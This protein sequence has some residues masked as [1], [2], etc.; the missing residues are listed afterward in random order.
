MLV[1]FFFFIIII[2]NLNLTIGFSINQNEDTLK[3]D[4]IYGG[5]I[6]EKS[7]LEFPQREKDNYLSFNQSVLSTRITIELKEGTIRD[8]LKIISS[9]TDLKLIYHDEIVKDKLFD[10]YVYDESVENIL[11][12]IFKE[13]GI[14]FILTEKNEIIIA[15]T[16]KIDEETGSI[17]GTVRDQSGEPLIG[18]NVII[19]ENKLR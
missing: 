18:A 3:S 8:V 11:N 1:Q 9:K 6:I 13:K 12:Q 14:S 15:R 4:V 16:Q 10:F 5:S 17:Q 7:N 2:F 19:K